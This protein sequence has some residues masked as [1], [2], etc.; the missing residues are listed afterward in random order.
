MKILWRHRKRSE[1]DPFRIL[2]CGCKV[3]IYDNTCVRPCIS[4][5]PAP[6]KI[7]EEGGN[8]NN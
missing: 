2:E 5:D 8:G 1:T 6:P 4:H 3:Y 7:E